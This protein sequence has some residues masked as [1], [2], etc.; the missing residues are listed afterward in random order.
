MTEVPVRMDSLRRCQKMA[1]RLQELRERRGTIEKNLD[2][3]TRA[4]NQLGDKLGVT[5]LTSLPEEHAH[6]WMDQF[7][8]RQRADHRRIE[9]V[10]QIADQQTQVTKRS[11]QISQYERDQQ[12]LVSRLGAPSVEQVQGWIQQAATVIQLRARQAELAAS[13]ESN[14]SGRPLDEFLQEL[15]TLNPRSVAANVSTLNAQVSSLDADVTTAQQ[16]VGG[17]AREL[18]FKEQGRLLWRP[19]NVSSVCDPNWS[20]CRS[21]GPF[22]SWPANC[23]RAPSIASRAITNP[24]CSS[25]RVDS[26]KN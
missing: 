20:N 5:K 21:N 26:S 12:H 3:F 13:L 2:E 8:H 6:V 1:G 7:L 11:A 16:E 10:H 14:A 24:S 25:I 9:L 17:M 23:S 22:T 15:S 4:V 19:N 18:E